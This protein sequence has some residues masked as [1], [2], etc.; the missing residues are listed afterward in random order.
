[1]DVN[2][3]DSVENAVS[4]C[5]KS[6]LFWCDLLFN[7]M[8]WDQTSCI[9]TEKDTVHTKLAEKDK[10]HMIIIQVNNNIKICL[11][12]RETWLTLDKEKQR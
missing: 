11:L 9:R 3:C 6:K 5:T 2:L 8:M 1:M 7:F 10:A 12:S 4:L